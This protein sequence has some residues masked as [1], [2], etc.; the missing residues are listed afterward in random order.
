MAADEARV[1]DVLADPEPLQ[2]LADGR[3]QHLAHPRRLEVAALKQAHPKAA[4]GQAQ[5][6]GGTGGS[7]TDDRDVERWHRGPL[8]AGD[9]ARPRLPTAGGAGFAPVQGRAACRRGV[10]GAGSGPADASAPPC[11]RRSRLRRPI[12]ASDQGS[13]R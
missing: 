5:A 6:G 3:S 11:P 8:A 4:A 9:A 13:G 1:V 7:S 10:V 12:R 2:E